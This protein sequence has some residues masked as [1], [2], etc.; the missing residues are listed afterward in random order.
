MFNR[1]LYPHIEAPDPDDVDG[2]TT[3]ARCAARE[4]R[5]DER[6]AM[7]RELAATGMAFNAALMRE[8]QAVEAAPAEDRPSVAELSLAYNRV[9]RAVRQTLAL[10]IRIEEMAQ[11]RLKAANDDVFDF[12]AEADRVRAKVF[13][14]LGGAQE[15]GDEARARGEAYP[16]AGEIQWARDHVIA[17]GGDDEDPESLLAI[18]FAPY[19]AAVARGVPGMRE[20]VEAVQQIWEAAGCDPKTAPPGWWQRDRGP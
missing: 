9:A 16:T 7:L 18:A 8:L 2:A 17:P 1:P 10:E 13:A 11:A 6:E 4:A 15:E 20:Y 5:A 14:M 3:C 19:K 12:Q